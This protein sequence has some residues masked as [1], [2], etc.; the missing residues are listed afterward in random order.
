[1]LYSARA[2][3]SSSGS[4]CP[5]PS[6]SFAKLSSLCFPDSLIAARGPYSGRGKNYRR[7]DAGRSTHV[8]L[9]SLYPRRQSRDKMIPALSRFSHTA[10]DRKLGVGPGNEASLFAQA[11]PNPHYVSGRSPFMVMVLEVFGLCRGTIHVS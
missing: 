1:M 5:R 4:T 2:S 3:A 10:S 6:L 7:A 11:A 9:S 8:Q